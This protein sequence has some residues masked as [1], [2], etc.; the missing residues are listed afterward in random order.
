MVLHKIGGNIDHRAWVWVY[1][2]VQHGD[3]APHAV[4]CSFSGP[5]CAEVAGWE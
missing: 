2:L 5:E 4:K 3:K 1:T